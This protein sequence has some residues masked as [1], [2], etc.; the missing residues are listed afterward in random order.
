[1]AQILNI[2]P[3]HPQPRRIAQAAAML[4]QGALI[5]Y[6]TDSSYAFGCLMWATQAAQRARQIRALDDSH[7]FTLV[8]ADLSAVSA[9]AR[10]D[11][12][13]YRL[14]RAY[15][16]GPYTFVLKATRD[17]PRRLQHAKRRTVGLRVVGHPVA[18]AL[19]AALGEPLLS[20]TARL[21]G[22]EL[23]LNDASEIAERLGRRVDLII[24]SGPCSIEP[25][26]VV[27]LSEAQP[28]VLRRG[29]GDVSAFEDV[30]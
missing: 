11:N 15:T 6:P 25:T 19:L 9:Y 4:E 12:T 13:A 1:M 8:C 21:A 7:Y 20:T 14:L 23:A 28:R 30:A 29:L 18:R 5:V 17:V 27:D 22:D 10:V 24:D 26:S 2:H 3:T 16:P